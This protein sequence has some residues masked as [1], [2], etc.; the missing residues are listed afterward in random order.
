MMLGLLRR[1]KEID[2][3]IANK[4][5]NQPDALARQIMANWYLD[6]DAAIAVMGRL[7]EMGLNLNAGLIAN[8]EQG[9]FMIR[10]PRVIQFLRD[11]AAF[12]VKDPG[13]D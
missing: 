3:W 2:P 9:H 12:D 11:R 7:V 6:E 13:M 4:P 10:R 1:L 8:L 5:Q